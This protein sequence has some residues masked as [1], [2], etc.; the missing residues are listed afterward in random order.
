LRLALPSAHGLEVIIMRQATLNEEQESQ[1]E[2]KN[3]RLIDDG[4]MT[5]GEI[6]T[7]AR[8]YYG[9][10]RLDIERA[11]RIRESLITAIETGDIE[12]LPGRA[13][14]IGFVR[15]YAEYL[16]LDGDQIVQLYKTRDLCDKTNPILN[17]PEAAQEKRLPSPWIMAGSLVALLL[18]VTVGIVVTAQDR[19]AVEDVPAVSA[20]A[21][22]APQDVE[23]A[24]GAAPKETGIILNVR[25]DSWVEIKDTAG[26]E[27][28]SRVLN[29][30]D[31][32]FVPERSD[33]IM[34]LGNAGAIDISVHGQALPALGAQG[35]ILRGVRLDE[36]ALKA[37][38]TPV[39]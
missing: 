33:L 26:N 35:A 7:R 11:I 3:D 13:Y 36:A 30:G 1:A 22:I 17:F 5:V 23:P 14:A 37:L 10:S 27:I 12:S 21:G 18:F 39:E 20:D 32:Y 15:S 16:Q 34:S 19:S 4:G 25:E 6:L 8:E 28:V 31:R 2:V 38:A 9:L 24:A 29:A